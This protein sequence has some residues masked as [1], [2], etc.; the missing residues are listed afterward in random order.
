VGRLQAGAAS[1]RLQELELNAL[2][3]EVIDAVSMASGRQIARRG[4]GTPLV[5]QWDRERLLDALSNVVEN[6]TLY[7]PEGP[8]VVEVRPVAHDCAEIVVHDEGVGIPAD[9]RERIFERFWRGSNPAVDG[10]GLGLYVTRGILALQGGQIWVQDDAHASGTAFVI[11]LPLAPT[12][13]S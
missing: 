3:G 5:G 12:G 9:E 13:A 8:I 2:V 11:R 1:L 7:A 10:M 4:A 6:A